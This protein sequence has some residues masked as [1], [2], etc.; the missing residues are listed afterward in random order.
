MLWGHLQRIRRQ[1]VTGGF[2]LYRSGVWTT[3]F[4]ILYF[5]EGMLCRTNV[6]YYLD[7]K[8]FAR[9]L[10]KSVKKFSRKNTVLIM[11]CWTHMISVQFYR[12]TCLYDLLEAC[13]SRN[14]D[15]LEKEFPLWMFNWGP[16]HSCPSKY[17][18]FLT[19]RSTTTA[20]RRVNLGHIQPT[21]GSLTIIVWLFDM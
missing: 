2:W 18:I 20:S 5:K 3:L 1:M 11:Y 10:A 17:L 14:L 6:V 12:N 19:G 7:K 13:D 4:M 16:W 21:V 15:L 9:F 8:K